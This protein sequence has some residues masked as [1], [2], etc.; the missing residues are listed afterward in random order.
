M[1]VD[2]PFPVDDFLPFVV[3]MLFK[4]SLRD[5]DDLVLEPY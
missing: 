1:Q 3:I 2:G 5:H 4:L